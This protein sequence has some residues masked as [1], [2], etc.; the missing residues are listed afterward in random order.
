MNQHEISDK[1][2]RVKELDG[3][4]ALAILLVAA[5]HYIDVRRGS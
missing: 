3:L 2:Q 4:R 1:T 5:W